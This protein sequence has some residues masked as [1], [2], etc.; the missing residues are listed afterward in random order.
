MGL[1]GAIRRK[2]YAIID[3]TRVLIFKIRNGYDY[4]DAW[5]IDSAF[6][7]WIIPLLKHLKKYG[8]TVPSNLPNYSPISLDPE[9]E[10]LKAWRNILQEMIDGFEDYKNDVFDTEPYQYPSK[11]FN[12]A[13]ELFSE[14]FMDLWD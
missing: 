4:R 14:Y 10:E 2:L 12:R 1:F 8:M 3:N 11:K 5:S 7:D 6:C 13:M 9:N